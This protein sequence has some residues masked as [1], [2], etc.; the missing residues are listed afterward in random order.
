MLKRWPFKKDYLL[1]A[2]TVLLFLI[3]YQLA[4]KLTINDWQLN[5]QLT[6]EALQSGDLSYQPGYLERKDRNLEKILALYRSDTTLFR[7][8]TLSA[9]AALAEK[10]RVKL[11]DVP[12]QES[13]Y[14]TGRSIVQK[15]SFE[16]DF[17]ALNGFLNQLESLGGVGMSRAVN[18]KTVR[19]GAE[20]GSGKLMLEVYMEICK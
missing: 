9:I 10:N 6:G 7:S 3:C 12:V 16:G 18:F 15:L 8:S 5:R 14:H 17:F 4:F 11:T 13:V 20:P 1:I 19:K 2:G